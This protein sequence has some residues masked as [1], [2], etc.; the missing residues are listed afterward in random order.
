MA[1]KKNSIDY[2]DKWIIEH[3]HTTS[4][5]DFLAKEYNKAHGTNIRLETFQAHCRSKLGLK[6]RT[7]HNLPFS[8]EEDQFL[9]QYYPIMTDSELE[10]EFILRFG[11]K[12]ERQGLRLRCWYLGICKLPEVILKSRS[13]ATRSELGT[14]YENQGYLFVKV[15]HNGCVQDKWKL[16]QRVVWEAAYGEIPEGHIILF[17]DG[18]TKN[19]DLDN[20]AC[21]PRS[22]SGYIQ[23]NFHRSDNPLITQTQIVWCDLKEATKGL[24]K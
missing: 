21:V 11:Y 2:D 6:R 22:Y 1:R 17:L 19:C 9:Y 5:T 12:R 10:T 23:R 20:L 14:E 7:I 15:K 18:N 8:K 24:N 16:K 3:Y 13:E 4:R